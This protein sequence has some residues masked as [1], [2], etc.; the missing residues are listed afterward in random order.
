MSFPIRPKAL[1]DKVI[2]DLKKYKAENKLNDSDLARK[3]GVSAWTVERWIS[4]EHSPQAKY[5]MK[6][7]ECG[8][9]TVKLPEEVRKKAIT[10]V[11]VNI[12]KGNMIPRRYRKRVSMPDI[13]RNQIKLLI[14]EY[15]DGLSQ[16]RTFSE[17]SESRDEFINRL[18]YTC[19]QGE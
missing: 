7:G 19:Q 5:I 6:M 14:D 3:I 4:G 16:A 1:V 12:D 8:I 9:T 13:V 10:S 2:V 18:Y 17:F 15:V 11:L